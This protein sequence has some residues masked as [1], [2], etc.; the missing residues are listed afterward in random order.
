MMKAVAIALF[1]AFLAPSLLLAGPKDPIAVLALHYRQASELEPVIRPMLAPDDAMTAT[2]MQ[3]ILRTDP[4]TLSEIK[5]LLDELDRAPRNLLITVD[6]PQTRS[7]SIN[8]IQG[9]ISAGN[10]VR[11]IA[12]NAPRN[13]SSV[14]IYN[15]QNVTQSGGSYQLRVLE[16]QRALISAG[17]A[18][19]VTQQV[20]TVGPGGTIV[21]QNVQ[22]ASADNG[23]YVLP[24]LAG[25]TVTLEIEPRQE[26]FKRNGVI[27]SQRAHTTVSGRLGE[28]IQIGGVSQHRSSGGSGTLYRS[29]SQQNVESD[30]RVKV[31]VANAQSR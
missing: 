12:G 24:R 30:I 8:S 23:F 2:G 9:G 5:T 1:L 14:H 29:E 18:A 6:S 17:V 25:D 16:G 20:V 28:W 26:S 19:P 15:S 7:S 22:Y 13:G 3:I 4:D 21:Q 11:V 31:D 10:D 27:E